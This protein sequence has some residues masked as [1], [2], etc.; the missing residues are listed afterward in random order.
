MTKSFDYDTFLT[1]SLEIIVHSKGRSFAQVAHEI[2]GLGK[3]YD[4][5]RSMSAKKY[6][7]RDL[8]C[9]LLMVAIASCQPTVVVD[10]LYRHN[11]R[12]GFNNLHA[13]VST[14]IDYAHY[15]S[16]R[17]NREKGLRALQKVRKAV[18]AKKRV[19]RGLA[20]NCLQAIDRSIRILQVAS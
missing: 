14:A 20:K 16:Q 3:E 1:R 13:Q 19:S 2:E 17:E 18:S 10:R 11:V 4:G 12:Q 9:R 6:I 7:R 8:D 5:V 15:W